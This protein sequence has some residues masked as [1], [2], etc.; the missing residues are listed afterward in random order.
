MIKIADIYCI[1][2]FTK[3]NVVFLLENAPLITIHPKSKLHK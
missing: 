3:L 2:Y 1:M